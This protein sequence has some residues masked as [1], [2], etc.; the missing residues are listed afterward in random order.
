MG[1]SR[2]VGLTD[3][4]YGVDAAKLITCRCGTAILRHIAT[5]RRRRCRARTSGMAAYFFPGN[6]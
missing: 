4:I 3:R 6:V 5:L 2:L 1:D